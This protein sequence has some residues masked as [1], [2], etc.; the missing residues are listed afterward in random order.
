MILSMSL[1]TDLFYIC[2][3]IAKQPLLWLPDTPK[4][5]TS[6]YSWH[7]RA[8]L[9]L[10][11][12]VLYLSAIVSYSILTAFTTYLN[13]S[14]TERRFTSFKKVTRSPRTALLKTE[15]TTIRIVIKLG[16][17]YTKNSCIDYDMF[18]ESSDENIHAPSDFMKYSWAS[19]RV[20]YISDCFIIQ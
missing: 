13:V 11:V 16:M 3:M 18:N 7:K 14:A 10:S 12:H 4:I 20:A 19:L 9:T 1:V 15:I 2:G 17:S 5:N 8:F 6:M